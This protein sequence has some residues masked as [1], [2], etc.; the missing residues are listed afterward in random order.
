MTVVVSECYVVVVVRAR[1]ND[2]DSYRRIERTNYMS[3]WEASL[4][5][6]MNYI[7]RHATRCKKIKEYNFYSNTIM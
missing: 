6:F 4:D 5:A 1:G 3:D 2:D 7:K